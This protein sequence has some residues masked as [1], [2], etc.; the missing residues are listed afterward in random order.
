MIK[1]SFTIATAVATTAIV[2]TTPLLVGYADAKS[3]SVFQRLNG[4]WR[5]SGRINLTNGRARRIS[6]RA[7]YNLKNKGHNLGFA[8]RCA[9]SDGKIDLRARLRATNG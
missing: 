2:S 1:Y 3:A 5:G 6:C 7:Y 4:T 8:I 9:S